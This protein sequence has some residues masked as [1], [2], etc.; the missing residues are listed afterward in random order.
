MRDIALIIFL[1][2]TIPLAFRRPV[3]GVLLW[4]WMS[5]MTPHR[6]TYGF[7]FD[8]PFAMIIAI[9]TL[10]GWASTSDPKRFPV[11]GPMI[12]L[13]LFIFWISL[14]FP[15]SMYR[16]DSYEMWTKVLKIQLMTFAVVALVM[17]RKQIIWLVWVMAVSLGFYGVKGG[18]FTLR[19]GGGDKVWG[20]VGSFI[21]G[22]NELALALLMTIP[23]MWYLFEMTSDKRIRVGLVGAMLLTGMAAL[24]TQ[25]RGALLGFAAMVV[26]FWWYSKRKAA[27]GLG[28]LATVPFMIAFMPDSWGLRMNTILEYDKDQSAT[29]RINA[30]WNAFNLANDHPIFGGGFEIYNEEVFAR[31]APNPGD[32]HAAHSIY[33]QVLGEHGWIAFSIFMLMCLATWNT[34]VWL[35]KN[36]TPDGPERWAYHLGAMSQVSFAAFAVGGAFLSLAYFDLPYFLM[37]TLVAAR[38]IITESREKARD[39]AQVTV[40]ENPEQPLSAGLTR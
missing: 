19:S 21:E 31:Y 13:A 5:L 36:T 3:Y 15:F 38:A 10:I 7:A 26:T 23:L 24:G 17:E 39:P 14:G 4:T 34:A 2:L 16:D 9:V 28:L 32:V 30:W 20:P 33:F 29:G 35:R 22:N 40:A 37:A 18:W 25:S 6:L 27:L 1:A 8:Q 11:R 12:L